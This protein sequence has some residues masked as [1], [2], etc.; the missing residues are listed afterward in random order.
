MKKII[1]NLRTWLIHKLGGLTVEESQ[2][3]DLNSC[4]I[5]KR[6]AYI[7]LLDY[8]K[9]TLY[10]LPSDEWCKLMYNR[11]VFLSVLNKKS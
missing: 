4:E 5:G 10:G 2:A 7:D 1:R 8:A 6:Q 11:L 3:S 9:N